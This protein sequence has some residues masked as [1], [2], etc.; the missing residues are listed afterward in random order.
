M[1]DDGKCRT[2][3]GPIEEQKWAAK[4]KANVIT[5]GYDSCIHGYSMNEDLIWNYSFTE[6]VL[7]T[8]TG[9]I[10]AESDRIL[11]ETAL[12]FLLPV[13]VAEAPVHAG[14]VARLCGASQSGV[15]GIGAIGLAEQA[16]FIVEQHRGLLEWLDR[17]DKRLPD[18]YHA[19]DDEERRSV[20]V[21]RNCVKQAGLEINGLEE[22]PSRISSI[23]MM[24]HA[25]GLRKSEQ[26]ELS[27]VMARIS[28]ITA[29]AL[30]VEP[31]DFRDYPID[32]PPFR[33]QEKS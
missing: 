31:G 16:R 26:I 21:I 28:S 8:L 1:T 33:Y 7:L 22:N 30:N 9:E 10:P 6:T 25:C 32:L 15:T 14:V 29:E 13:S 2:Y 24:L 20:D 18:E 11:F 5:P 23:I 27:I 17:E 3:S 19:A 4:L 12:K